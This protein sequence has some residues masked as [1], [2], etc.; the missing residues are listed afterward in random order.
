M[1]LWS[2]ALAAAAN[3]KSALLAINCTCARRGCVFTAVIFTL[4][5]S[6]S[7]TGRA[8]CFMNTP[9]G[10]YSIRG[11]CCSLADAGEIYIAPTRRS[12]INLKRAH[13]HCRFIDFH[14]LCDC[15]AARA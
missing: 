7:Q 11:E 6:D 10:I 2:L 14:Y 4:S 3:E 15:T 1:R 13:T 12:Q 8:I 5:H 9:L